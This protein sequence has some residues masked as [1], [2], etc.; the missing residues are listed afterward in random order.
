MASYMLSPPAT[1]DLGDCLLLGGS[2]PLAPECAQVSPLRHNLRTHL[3]GERQTPT[4]TLT[5][6]TPAIWETL[7]KPSRCWNTL[8]AQTCSHVG[9][10]PPGILN[11][12]RETSETWS[13][14]F[15]ALVGFSSTDLGL[16]LL[17]FS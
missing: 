14:T 16:D 7:E 13:R 9:D 15:L 11:T 12:S 8:D 4:Q 17:F 10:T 2:R 5:S 1:P 6:E 3:A